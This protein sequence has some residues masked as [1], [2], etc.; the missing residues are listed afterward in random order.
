MQNNF[1]SSVG[2]PGDHH[3]PKGS[4]SGGAVEGMDESSLPIA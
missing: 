1:D 3:N 4:A 2:F